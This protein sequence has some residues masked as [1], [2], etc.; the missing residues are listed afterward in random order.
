MPKES[1]NVK[2]FADIISEKAHSEGEQS[3]IGD[4]I[5]R[6]QK[7]EEENTKLRNTIKQ[8]IELIA[9]TEEIVKKAIIDK[10]NLEKGIS[11]KDKE[12]KRKDAE[13]SLLKIESTMPLPDKPRSQ[14]LLSQSDLQVNQSLIEDLQEQLELKKK[15]IMS[16]QNTIKNNESRIEELEKV[17]ESLT[18]QSI[19]RGT[20][21]SDRSGSQLA[22]LVQDLQT[23]INR[24]KSNISRLKAENE[25]L[26]DAIK[27]GG[28]T[29]ENEAIKQLTIENESLSN[30]LSDMEQIKSK[31]DKK[32]KLKEL[33]QKIAEKDHLI[34]RL[35]KL[36]EKEDSEPAGEAAAPVSGLVEE[37]QNKINKLSLAL[38]EKDSIISKLKGK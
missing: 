16:F 18:G 22:S 12:L 19:S 7:I 30:Q 28:K 1:D 4:F 3:V 9:K 5:K 38:K 17:N 20:S 37:L 21:G 11:E 32:E 23:E 25:E 36:T 2:G 35:V 15:Q 8:D 29:L 31:K 10:Q 34:E 24:Y 27:K 6:I 14:E 26:K 33:Y 13:I